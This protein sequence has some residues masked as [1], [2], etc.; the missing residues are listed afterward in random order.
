[1]KENEGLSRR[2]FLKGAA[3]VGIAGAAAG[4]IGG[5]SSDNA[6]A[7]DSKTTATDSAP[8]EQAAQTTDW[9]GG[10]NAVNES[11][12]LNTIETEVLVIG[13]GTA[14]C[15]AACAAV[16][17]GAK[18]I[19]IDKQKELGNGIR[20]TMAAL[21]SKQQI[22]T[23]VNP[24]K[25][26]IINEMTRHSSG[27][28][29]ERLYRVW[30][31]YSGE[32][33]D[34]YTERIAEN[35]YEIKF[36]IS[37]PG[38][39][40]TPH[41]DVGHSLQ[42]SDPT[43]PNV[44]SFTMTGGFLL[45]YG[46]GLG[47]EVHMNTTMTQLV[48]DGERVTGLYAET[49]EGI[50]EYKASKGVIVCTG[51]YAA[52]SEMMEALQPETL[53]MAS[54]HYAFP[55]CDGEGIKAMLWAGAAMDPVHAGMI[56]DRGAVPPDSTD[57]ADGNFFWMGSQPFLKVDLEGNRFTN[58]SGPYDYILHTANGIKDK[59]YCTVWDANYAEDILRFDTHGCS[60]LYPYD[61]GALPVMPLDPVVNG[62]NAELM[63]AGVIVT[64]DTVEEL[65]EKLNIPADSFAETVARYNGFADAGVD[66]DFGKEA[67]RLSHLDTP[68]FF[69]V[70]QRGGYFITTLDGVRIDEQMRVCDETGSPIEGLY[71]AGDCSGGYY[72][73]S[74]VNLLA[75]D[76]AGRSVT[77]G[78]RAGKIAANL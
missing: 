24:D 75:G 19:I 66:E 50:V 35:G 45:E 31:D 58:E 43:D 2:A 44:G 12:I 25:F 30:A 71:A 29:D 37:T 68:P 16:E 64:A 51:G 53:D 39:L 72:G 26:T 61:N 69:G 18:T 21:N 62:M 78:R 52:N 41:Y 59:T 5:C 57:N 13:A 54:V 17:E 36:E 20:D 28:G 42:W 38:T 22:E 55:S 7:S 11:D 74:Y 27:F 63:E 49:E 23:G 65:A 73:I 3:T 4:V 9:L 8:A 33:I 47:L 6:G 34:W 1:M 32:A 46:K 76:A 67:H 56:F 14:G 15:F 60:R 10:P 70:R 77:F 48:K 40:K